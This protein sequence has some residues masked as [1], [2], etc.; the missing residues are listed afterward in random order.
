[1]P[2]LPAAGAT[3]LPLE[4][5]GAVVGFE[6][7]EELVHPLIVAMIATI[8][9][10]TKIDRYLLFIKCLTIGYYINGNFTFIFYYSEKIRRYASFKNGS[11]KQLY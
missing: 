11:I 4:V 6:V 5:V 9:V 8:I 10:I 1:L 7:D 2:E 3:V